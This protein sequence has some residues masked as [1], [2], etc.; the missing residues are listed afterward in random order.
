[1]R[2]SR[3]MAFAVVALFAVAACTWWFVSGRAISGAEGAA[4]SA[5]HILLIGASIGQ[6][7][8]LAGWPSR[9]GAAGYSA[10][11]TAVWEF[12]KTAAVNE[13]LLRPKRP[14]KLSRTWLKGLFS[15]PPAVPDVVILKECSSYFPRDLAPAEAVFAGWAKQLQT[16]GMKVMLATV[17]PVTATRSARDPGK[18]QGL[19][20]FNEWLRRH[21]A[22]QGYV[23]LD[24]EAAMRDDTPEGYLR[25][26]Y[27]SGD[28]SHLNAAAYKVL[29]ERLAR[30][31]NRPAR[32]DRV[33]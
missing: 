16:R 1:M 32:F 24:L 18:Q 22:E 13:T 9:V 29:D 12:D 30:T 3:R 26:I 6:D 33:K 8:K 15:A 5:Q 4:R 21:A 10:E 20:Q 25:D 31:L 28:G 11:S 19:R 7:W 17:V 27:T 2:S 23:L 14:F